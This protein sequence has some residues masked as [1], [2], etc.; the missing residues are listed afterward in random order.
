MK[1]I[2]S[3]WWF[4]SG[5]AAC[6]AAWAFSAHAADFRGN[7]PSVADAQIEA[8]ADVTPSANAPVLAPGLIQEL[9]D[10]I[11]GKEVTELRTAYNARY[12]ASLLFYPQ[13]MGYYVAMF[14]DG[15]FWRVVKVADESGAE[16]LYS[17]F[18]QQTQALAEVEIRRTVLEAQQAIMQKELARS[19][20]RLGAVRNDLNIQRKH[21]QALVRDQ[22]A[23]REQASAL[24]SE[25][26]SA[27]KRLDGL[28]QRVGALQSEQSG[29]DVELMRSIK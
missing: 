21:E 5:A 13:T 17:N 23:A 6:L 12:G 18:V 29:A 25:N 11:Q 27:L 24:E 7:V 9:R 1:I 19:E 4:C 26:A 16:A 2:E 3:R 8:G 22:K 15:S 10:R 14:H 20:A 28:Q